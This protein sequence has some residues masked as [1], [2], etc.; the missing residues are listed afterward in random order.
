MRIPLPPDEMSSAEAAKPLGESRTSMN[1][2]WIRSILGPAATAETSISAGALRSMM[3]G[4]ITGSG[5]TPRD[6]NNVGSVSPNPQSSS[7]ASIASQARIESAM[8]AI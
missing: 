8:L 3:V 2:L 1:V 6:V 4:E 5:A 7:E